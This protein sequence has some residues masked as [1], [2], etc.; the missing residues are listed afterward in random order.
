METFAARIKEI[1]KQRK[2]TQK[3]VA[4]LANIDVRLYQYYEA[5]TLCPSLTN[6]INIADILAVSLD[7]LT[8]RSDNPNIN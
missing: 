3:G 2:L 1:R 5:G 4:E 8:G 7:Y 6:A